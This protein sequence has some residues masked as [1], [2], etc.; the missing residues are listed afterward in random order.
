VPVFFVIIVLAVII[1]LFIKQK[2]KI[3]KRKL[4]Y[5]KD[6]DFAKLEK[7]SHESPMKK[8]EVHSSATH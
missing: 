6:P 2:N 7:I 8:D 3:K 4:E 5:K 1:I